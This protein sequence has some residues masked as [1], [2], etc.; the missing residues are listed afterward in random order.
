MSALTTL[1]A[2]SPSELD[3]G[4]V[5]LKMKAGAKIFFGG[6]VAI[7]A[8]GWAVPASDTT[9]LKVIGRA[10]TPGF[11]PGGGSLSWLSG[12]QTYSVDNTSGGNGALTISVDIS[13]GVRGGR[14][15]LYDIDASVPLTQALLFTSVY[16]RD[17]H[18]VGASSTNSIVAGTF[19]G[20]PKDDARND[21]TTQAWI[22][23]PQ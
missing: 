20:F 7:D 22:K 2:P 3:A 21:I 8:N 14:W 11:R 13:A 9:G 19:M 1:Y 16:V 15:F 12:A 5:T 6:M 18:T 4:R 10:V 17:D 23:F